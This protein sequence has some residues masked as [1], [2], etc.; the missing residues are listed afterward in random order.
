M[1][2]DVARF[3]L[4]EQV[5]Q[6]WTATVEVGTTLH[7][8]LQP[9]FLANVSSR[10]RPYDRIRI[11]VDTGEWYSE[12]LVLSCGRVW[13]KLIPIFTLDLTTQDVETSQADAADR[14]LIQYRG[15]HLKFCV[16]RRTDKAP[17]KEQLENKAEAQ[18]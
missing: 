18:A 7:D 12:L 5:N 1:K 8:V 11:R 9:E 10:L 14:Y 16:I 13:A 3:A 4:D 15:P 6:D 2:L 17:I